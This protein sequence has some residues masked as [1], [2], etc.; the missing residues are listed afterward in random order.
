MP[1]SRQI[2]ESVFFPTQS[3]DEGRLKYAPYP[4]RKI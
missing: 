1:Y 2:M 4:L 3:D